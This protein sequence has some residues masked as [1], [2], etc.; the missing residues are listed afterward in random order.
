MEAQSLC[1]VRRGGFDRPRGSGSTR[2]SV[3]PGRGRAPEG[4]PGPVPDS[5]EEIQQSQENDQRVPAEV[6]T[7]EQ[8]EAGG[9]PPH[10]DAD[11]SDL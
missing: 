5:G 3:F 8:P 9:A 4:N 6:R 7:G 2:P 10:T 11:L 1:K